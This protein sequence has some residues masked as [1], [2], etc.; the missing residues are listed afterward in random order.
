MTSWYGEPVLPS[1]DNDGR[2][3]F[4]TNKLLLMKAL[5]DVADPLESDF[6]A[7]PPWFSCSK[8]FLKK[9]DCMFCTLICIAASQVEKFP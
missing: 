9:S 3:L 8:L 4:F 7:S 2:F 5:S 6:S 1:A